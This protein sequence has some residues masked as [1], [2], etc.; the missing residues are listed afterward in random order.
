MIDARA[1]LG[2]R[3]THSWLQQVFTSFSSS[4]ILDLMLSDM[5]QNSLYQS[6][7]LRSQSIPQSA[8]GIKQTSSASWNGEA[9]T[10][11]YLCF[12]QIQCRNGPVFHPHIERCKTR[13]ILELGDTADLNSK[14]TP[15]A[16]LL[17]HSTEFIL[18][19][20]SRQYIFFW[21]PN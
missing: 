20:F 21:I 11:N 17:L 10:T 2:S 4:W 14:S 7:I 18:R 19:D 8:G 15:Y 5:L 12:R 16:Q 9:N 1:T 6:R 3:G 13:E